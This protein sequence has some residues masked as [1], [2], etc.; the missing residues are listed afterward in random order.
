MRL[1]FLISVF[2]VLC[3][4]YCVDC[5]S[6]SLKKIDKYEVGNTILEIM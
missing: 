5:F 4:I 2:T 6:S 1:L 3:V